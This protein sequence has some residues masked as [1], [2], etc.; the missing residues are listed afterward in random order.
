MSEIRATEHQTS[1]PAETEQQS[2]RAAE[3][4]NIKNRAVEQQN[5]RTTVNYGKNLF[6][7]NYCSTALLRCCS[8]FAMVFIFGSCSS[9]SIEDNKSSGLENKEFVIERSP[10]IEKVKPHRPVKI[11][12][13]RDVQGRY[14][15]ELS[16]ENT[17][18]IIKTDRRLRRAFGSNEEK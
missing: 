11:K 2:S 14:S 17:E 18:E 10:D 6:L 7:K 4:Q 3:Q 8:I 15:W 5:S 13:K 12:V 1:R 16:G 9:Q